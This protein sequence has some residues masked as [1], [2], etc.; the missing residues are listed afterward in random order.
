MARGVL[1]CG[2]KGMA[3]QPEVVVDGSRKMCI[4]FIIT[5]C[6]AKVQSGILANPDKDASPTSIVRSPHG[7]IAD[8]APS[9]TLQRK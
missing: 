9:N 7:R 8:I 6:P 3:Q 2:G 1:V 4:F 5:T